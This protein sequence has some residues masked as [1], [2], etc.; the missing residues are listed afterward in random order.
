MNRDGQTD[1]GEPAILSALYDGETGFAAAL[2]VGKRVLGVFSEDMLETPVRIVP[3]FETLDPKDLFHWTGLRGLL[4]TWGKSPEDVDRMVWEGLPPGVEGRSLGKRN[5]VAFLET[6][7]MFYLDRKTSTRKTSPVERVLENLRWALKALGEFS[8][9]PVLRHRNFGPEFVDE[10]VLPLIRARSALTVT[11]GTNSEAVRILLK[12]QRLFRFAGPRAM[13]DR[14]SPNRAVLRL[15]E[16]ATISARDLLVC[17]RRF[18]LDSLKVVKPLGRNLFLVRTSDG[19]EPVWRRVS[20]EDGTIFAEVATSGG[21][22]EVVRLLKALREHGKEGALLC[23]KPPALDGSL[24]ETPLQALDVFENGSQRSMLLGSFL[25]EKRRR[26]IPISEPPA[27]HRLMLRLSARCDWNCG[28]CTIRDLPEGRRKRSYED[29]MQA[30]REGCR[31]GCRSLVFMRGEPLLW[32]G[33]G[34]LVGEARRLG[35]E[36]IQV[37]THAGPLGQSSGLD[38]LLAPNGVDVFES[39][40]LGAK[41]ETHDRLAGRKGAFGLALRGVRKI[42]RA[43]KGW[44]AQAPVLEGNRDELGR[45]LDL[46]EKLGGRSVAFQFPRPVERNGRPVSRGLLSLKQAGETLRLVLPYAVKKGIAVQVEGMPDCLLPEKFRSS[47]G[48]DTEGQRIRIHDLHR[49]ETVDDRRRAPNA[50]IAR[51]CADCR[52]SETCGRTWPAYLERHGTSELKPLR[53]RKG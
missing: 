37:Q 39:P 21:L 19:A 11:D 30:L 15:P 26:A 29:A 50:A 52:L 32:P 8:R 16:G 18:L 53:R 44:T 31:A 6:G 27:A 36:W 22:P 23:R 10:E 49:L 5:G 17:D 41:P 38:G 51:I 46:V 34:E 14:P 2:L 40:I 42:I 20:G 12:G 33:F 35:Y 13:D 28:H 7:K 48:S 47:A 25:V 1:K 24:V 9:S 45:V 43:G 3:N 4:R